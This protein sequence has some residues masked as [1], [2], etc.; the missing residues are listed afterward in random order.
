MANLIKSNLKI[1]APLLKYNRQPRVSDT[2]GP[3]NRIQN[4]HSKTSSPNQMT[5]ML[6][7]QTTVKIF[8]SLCLEHIKARDNRV[9]RSNQALILMGKKLI[10]KNFTN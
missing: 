9:S 6:P 8:H 7:P 10:V 1:F 3:K 2:V 4:L 5:F